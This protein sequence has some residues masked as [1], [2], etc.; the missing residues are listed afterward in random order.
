MLNQ[1]KKKIECYE[2][3]LGNL[4]NYYD[5]FDKVEIVNFKNKKYQK[6]HF[7]AIYDEYILCKATC[8]QSRQ[9]GGCIKSC[10]LKMKQSILDVYKK[11][12]D[13]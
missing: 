11:I 2:N 1:Y 3:H 12:Y 5:C 7:Q 13:G 6:M 10:N 4:T 8:K 9:E